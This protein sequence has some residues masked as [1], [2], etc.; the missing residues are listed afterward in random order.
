MA[1]AGLR[2]QAVV[3]LQVWRTRR[4]GALVHGAIPAQLRYW[5]DMPRWGRLPL[6]KAVPSTRTQ[7][8]NR[9]KRWAISSSRVGPDQQKPGLRVLSK[10][11]DRVGLLEQER[12]RR[13]VRLW[14]TPLQVSWLRP[15]EWC[16]C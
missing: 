15:L 3:V 8:A 6:P 7:R 13:R 5:W 4:A 1:Q 16:K 10:L 2:L 14:V 9:S 11:L 12:R